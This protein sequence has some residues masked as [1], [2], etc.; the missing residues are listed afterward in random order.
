MDKHNV[1]VDDALK[2]LCEL[3]CFVHSNKNK[4]ENQKKDFFN[5]HRDIIQGVESN[6]G[7]INDYLDLSIGE[8]NYS[9]NGFQGFLNEALTENV[10]KIIPSFF[11]Y[12]ELQSLKTSSEYKRFQD[13][14]QKIIKDKDFDSISNTGFSNSTDKGIHVDRLQNLI[15]IKRDENYELLYIKD[16]SERNFFSDHLANILK[17]QEK[18]FLNTSLDDPFIQ[19]SIWNDSQK[20]IFAKTLL[21]SSKGEIINFY[22]T[23]LKHLDKKIINFTHKSLMALFLA[24]NTQNLLGNLS[25]KSCTKYLQDF[26]YFFRQALLEKV[27]FKEEQNYQL[28]VTIDLLNSLSKE[29]FFQKCSY[30][31]ICDF[32]ENKIKSF[33]NLEKIFQVKKSS[34]LF[35]NL[36]EELDTFFKKFPNGPLFKAVDI[37]I[38]QD[39][40][41]F[42]TFQLGFLPNY[43]GTLCIKD[44]KLIRISR[45]AAPIIQSS[46]QN[47]KISEE[48]L[49]FL[50][51]SSQNLNEK[52]LFVHLEDRKSL[53][54]RTRTKLFEELSERVEFHNNFYTITVPDSLDFLNYFESQY[55]TSNI[56]EFIQL[57]YLEVTS[58]DSFYFFSRSIEKDVFDFTLKVFEKIKNVFFDTK[59]SFFKNDKLFF[60]DIFSSLLILKSLEFTP[61]SLLFLSSK[62][63]LDEALSSWC[64]LELFITMFSKKEKIQENFIKRLLVSS[65]SPT[66]IMR[67]RLLFSRKVEVI[68]RLIGISNRKT[69][70]LVEGLSSVF[71]TNIQDWILKKS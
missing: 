7:N 49:N 25:A 29:L 34:Y 69:S 17:K 70:S 8:K 48:F 35:L 12:K 28:K 10:E 61:S 64:F 20:Q 58:N 55:S 63:G 27:S 40:L 71:L 31:D 36:Y 6:L 37:V 44:E 47:I 50:E 22:K 53:K 39:K 56:N 19:I 14:S 41:I 57:L 60:L 5:F 67:D 11:N 42:D 54:S 43:E 30:N 66:L 59:K 4:Q 18:K 68:G 65:L 46:L 26:I 51:F 15:D 1:S 13:L 21:Q 2:S 38:S 23:A 24:R 32:L 62:D 52:I 3:K 9:K 33:E 45:L 16:N